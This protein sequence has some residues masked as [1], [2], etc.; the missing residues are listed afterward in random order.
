MNKLVLGKL[1]SERINPRFE[2]LFAIGVDE[3]SWDDL[4]DAHYDWPEVAEVRVYRD[5]VKAAVNRVIDE[6]EITMPIAWDSPA[7]MILMG[8]EHERIHLETSSVLIRQLDLSLVNRPMLSF[9]MR[10]TEE[11]LLR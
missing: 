1:L 3:M 2:S 8:I 11:T 7:W 4:N 9:R 6:M 5:Q 10:P